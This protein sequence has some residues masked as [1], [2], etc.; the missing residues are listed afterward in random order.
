MTP[1]SGTTPGAETEVVTSAQA[2]DHVFEPLVSGQSYTFRIKATNLVG[3]SDWSEPTA[4]LQPG[5]EP[6]RPGLITFDS[7]TRT[8]IT[9]SFPALTGQDTGGS[10]ANP[11]ILSKYHIYYSTKES[12]D[13]QLLVAAAAA[14]PQVA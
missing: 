13:Y 11:I 1:W 5:V 9:F 6:T 14:T 12:S 7:T 10:A 8:T 4:A 2:T 3:T